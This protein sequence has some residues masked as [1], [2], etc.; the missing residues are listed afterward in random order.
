MDVSVVGVIVSV[1]LE[2]MVKNEVGLILMI[3]LGDIVKGWC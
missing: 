2:V 1:K 3:V